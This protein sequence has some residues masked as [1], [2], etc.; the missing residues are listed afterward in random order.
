MKKTYCDFCGNRFDAKDT[1]NRGT[2]FLAWRFSWS[3]TEDICCSCLAK[4]VGFLKEL[5]E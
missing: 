4:V 3:H 5:K 1:K 2:V